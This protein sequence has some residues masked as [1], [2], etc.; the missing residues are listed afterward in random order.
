M[1][2]K[3]VQ[4]IYVTKQMSGAFYHVFITEKQIIDLFLSFI[5]L[6]NF[7]SGFQLYDSFS[8]S[9]FAFISFSKCPRSV[10]EGD[11]HTW[12]SL[13]LQM[14]FKTCTADRRMV[15]FFFC[16]CLF[17]FVL[18][19]NRN[20]AL[21]EVKWSEVQWGQKEKSQKETKSKTELQGAQKQSKDGSTADT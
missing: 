7:A 8:F 18:T 14:C 11:A 20:F 6:N 10:A 12:S 15:P 16:C 17:H 1:K 21:N 9:H 13:L 19:V 5:H 4:Q 2:Q 3:Q